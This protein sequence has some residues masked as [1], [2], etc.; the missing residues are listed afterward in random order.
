[1][2]KFIKQNRRSIYGGLVT[3]FFVGLGVFLIENLSGY[4]AKQLLESSLPRINMLCNTIVLASATILALLLTLMGIG[5][6]MESK[7]KSEFYISILN[8]A[9]FDT[10]LFIVGLVLF[11]L[12]NIPVTESENVPSSWYVNIYW[13]VLFLSSFLSGFMVIVILMLYNTVVK[14]IKVAGLGSRDYFIEDDEDDDDND[15]DVK[16][17][18]NS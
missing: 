10:I 9:R 14:I 7:L 4:E 5:S 16:N 2:K 15:D 13:A 18:K 3:M 1:M 17:S 8:V 12:F 11:Q 6:G